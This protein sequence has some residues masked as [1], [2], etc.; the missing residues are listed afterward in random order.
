ML[1]SK[2]HSKKRRALF[3]PSYF[4]NGFGHISRC[5]T[6]ADEMSRRNWIVGMVLAGHHASKIRKAGY[7][8]FSP[9]FP[10]RS[11]PEAKAFPAYTYILD[12]NIQVLRD[13]F[14]RPWKVRAAVAE[15]LLVVRRFKPDVLI[16]DV[17]LLSWIVGQR[18]GI[19]VVQV[20][21]S[22]MHP[23]APRIIW[24]KDPPPGMI[25]PSIHKIFDK[26]LRRWKLERITRAEDL[27]RGDLFLVPSIPELE[28]LPDNTPNTH[29]IGALVS[30][31]NSGSQLPLPIEEPSDKKRVYVTMGGGAGP[32]GNL[33]LFEVINEA[34]A[35]TPWSVIVSTGPKFEAFRLPPAA[36]NLY[37]YQWV[38]GPSVI[39]QSDVVVF[40]GGYGTMMETVRYGVPAVVL[41]FHSEQEANGRR[42]AACSAAYVLSPESSDAPRQLIFK[43]W[44]YGEFAFWIHPV[45][46]ITPETLRNAVSNVLEKHCFSEGAAK[47]REVASKYK[48][49][50][51]A[52]NLIERL[53]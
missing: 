46:Q 36:P 51:A 21:R 13:G 42:L 48:G 45:Y 33:H 53:T 10:K 39:R 30:N 17:S 43:R 27:L 4:G 5:L 22:I 41:P 44:A 2:Y 16:G 26:V 25:S 23:V 24:W 34:F 1:Y 32:V 28:P 37:Y 8:V 9:W 35:D 7:E 6:L 20:I 3:F 40:H 18:A 29:Y 52:V 11:R 14:T 15:A 19:P 47:L 31:D 50:F 49:A 38:P 12:G